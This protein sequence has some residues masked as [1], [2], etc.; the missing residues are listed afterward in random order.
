MPDPTELVLTTSFIAALG[1][2]AS[3]SVA[4][5]MRAKNPVAASG[6]QPGQENEESPYESPASSEMPPALPT[7]KVPTWFYQ[8]LD[9]I[10]IGMI[11]LIFL[12]LVISSV[13]ASQKTDLVLDSKGLIASIGFQFFIA[14]A[15][16]LVMAMRVHPIDWLGLR[17]RSWPWVFLIAPGAVFLMWIF[18]GTLQAAGYMKWMESFG[19]ESVQETVK[20]LQN[21]TDPLVLGLMAFAA[22]IAAPICEELVFRGYFYPAAKKFAG[23][24][25]AGI[26][27]A[28]IF[29]SAHGSLSA[30]L[31]LF[32]FGCL[33]VLIYEKT[34]SLW[35][36]IAVHFCFNGATVLVQIAARYYHL[37]LDSIQ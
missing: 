6:L 26:F 2:F 10:G 19:V 23:P 7:G 30:L 8:P 22:V 15:V 17:W 14:G 3:S 9:L 34:G 5:K 24:W 27:S 13:R 29:A 32:I 18:F 16:L 25:A 37:P 33:L 12:A 31:P 20:L 21:S 36:P 28:L 1:I 11:Y 35:A 4:K